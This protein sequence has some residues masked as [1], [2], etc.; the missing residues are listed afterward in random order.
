M[1]GTDGPTVQ[2]VEA[3][4]AVLRPGSAGGSGNADYNAGQS[5]MRDMIAQ[6]MMTQQTA[7]GGAGPSAAWG[8]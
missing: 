6:Q 7:R 4:N 3:L 2:E 8:G 5:T 1:A